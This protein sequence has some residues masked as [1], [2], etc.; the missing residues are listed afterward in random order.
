ML[1]ALRGELL[2]VRASLLAVRHSLNNEE[3]V[4]AESPCVQN[5]IEET[6]AALALMDALLAD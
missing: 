3:M 5:A 6:D 2:S 4:N 1:K